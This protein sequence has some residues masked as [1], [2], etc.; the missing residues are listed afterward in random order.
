MMSV[1]FRAPGGRGF[2]TLD[3][4]IDSGADLCGFP[5]HLATALDLPP[6]RLAQAT[7]FLGKP[8]E[9]IVYRV[10]LE[11]DG[12]AFSRVE[13]LA[14]GRSYALIGRNV[15]CQLIVRLHGPRGQLELRKPRRN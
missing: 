1:R 2:A 4:M 14:L 10:D 11:I 9:T 3:A 5:E 13:A 12:I 15:L 8:L 7:G 6:V